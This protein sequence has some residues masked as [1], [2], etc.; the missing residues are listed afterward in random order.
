M[1]DDPNNDRQPSWLDLES[2]Q[3]MSMAEKITSLSAESIR[4]L[5]PDYVIQL[6]ERRQGVKLKHLLDI[7]NGTLR[8]NTS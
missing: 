2:V 5:Y 6:S 1:N 7:A 3:K 4:R 8:P